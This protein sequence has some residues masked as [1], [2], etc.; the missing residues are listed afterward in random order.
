MG[1]AH[2]KNQKTGD[3]TV[4]EEDM[5]V[6]SVHEEKVKPVVEETKRP[7]YEDS[8]L[9]HIDVSDKSAALNLI[10]MFLDVGFSRGAFTKAESEKIVQCIK[11]FEN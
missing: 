11:I 7:T 2:N 6:E 1:N 5:E 4:E 3:V 10:V 9:I 8:N